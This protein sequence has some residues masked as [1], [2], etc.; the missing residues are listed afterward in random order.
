MSNLI[1]TL[2]IIVISA[3]I[4]LDQFQQR[5]TYIPTL[6]ALFMM[7][8]ANK[9][10]SQQADRWKVFYIITFLTGIILMVFEIHIY[11]LTIINAIIPT[12]V[13]LTVGTI[14]FT[15]NWSN[16]RTAFNA[17]GIF[18]ALTQNMGSWGFIACYLFMAT[19]YHFANN[20]LKDL[21]FVIESKSS[22]T[23]PKGRR[24]ERKPLVIIDYYGF[25]KEL[26]FSFNDTKRVE[27]ADKVNVTVRKGLLGFDILEHY[28]VI[29]TENEE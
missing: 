25:K 1:N 14:A 20:E 19:N 23:G 6:P 2:T 17:K 22:M 9:T 21:S 29:E 26:V 12:S 15:I 24:N 18:S 5:K 13:I 10:I 4:N 7:N 16:S 3:M 28:D 8:R 11:R 27:K